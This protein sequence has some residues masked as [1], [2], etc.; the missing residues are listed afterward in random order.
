M[1]QDAPEAA[2]KARVLVVEDEF[3]IAREIADELEAVGF[4][5]LGPCPTVQKALAMLDESQCNAAI[6]DVSLR[7]GNS[8]QVVQ[9]LARQ[10]IP[11]IVL[12]GFSQNQ[13]PP[14]MAGA[15]VLAKPLHPKDLIHA[16]E[17]I[18]AGC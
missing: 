9:A 10:A 17:Q 1:S 3:F 8:L 18:L 13:L 2:V 7:N 15:P 4:T 11:F 5:V 14:E 12:T 16:L 6:L